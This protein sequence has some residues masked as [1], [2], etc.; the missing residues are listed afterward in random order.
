MITL[1][2]EKSSQIQLLNKTSSLFK[3]FDVL[4]S[5]ILRRSSYVNVR[6]SALR[7]SPVKSRYWFIMFGDTSSVISIIAKMFINILSFSLALLPETSLQLTQLLPGIC[8]WT[9]M[10]MHLSLLVLTFMSLVWLQGVHP[11]NISCAGCDSAL[12]ESCP[13]G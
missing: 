10:W 13:R 9:R 1:S 4:P 5:L 7:H 12:I 8:R 6:S 11:Q 2:K 3:V